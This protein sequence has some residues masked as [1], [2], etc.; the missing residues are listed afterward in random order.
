MREICNMTNDSMHT[1][2]GLWS[3]LLLS[4]CKRQQQSAA[5]TG[6]VRNGQSVTQPLH[7]TRLHTSIKRIAAPPTAHPAAQQVNVGSVSKNLASSLKLIAAVR[8]SFEEVSTIRSLLLC[9]ST[10]CL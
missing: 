4:S 6:P 7:K 10:A 1:K 2:T 9:G 3:A 5:F 8:G